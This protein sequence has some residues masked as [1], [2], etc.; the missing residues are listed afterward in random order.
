M[1]ENPELI[2]QIYLLKKSFY[3]VGGF[4]LDFSISVDKSLIIKFIRNNYKYK[5]CESIS[6]V[7]RHHGNNL[8]ISND[9]EVYLK[10]LRKF[11]FKYNHL[12]SI[13]I[14]FKFLKKYLYFKFKK[15]NVLIFHSNF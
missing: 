1:Y 8:T 10:N 5:V 4:D 9:L 11:Y 15:K 7:K 6:V 14:K 2:F 12:M 3:N 13:K